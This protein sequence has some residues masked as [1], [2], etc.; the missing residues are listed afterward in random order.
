M[1]NPNYQQTAL[2]GGF[3]NGSTFL[4]DSFM[5][6]TLTTMAF[7]VGACL[8]L[9][10]PAVGVCTLNGTVS[11]QQIRDGMN[12]TYQIVVYNQGAAVETIILTDT[13]SPYLTNVAY[14]YPSGPQFV[15]PDIQQVPGG[16]TLYS[17]NVFGL[18]MGNKASYTFTIAGIVL[19]SCETTTVSN[20]VYCKLDALCSAIPLE[21]SALPTPVVFQPLVTGLTVFM[22]QSQPAPVEGDPL[23]YMITVTNVG[24]ATITSLTVVDTVSAVLLS[25]TTTEAGFPGTVTAADVAGGT[26][27]V[28]SA[29]GPA[30]LVPGAGFV[31]TVS[32]T[33]GPVCLT[34][35]VGNTAYV[36]GTGECGQAEQLSNATVFQ[37]V[38]PPLD[39]TVVNEPCKQAIGV[40]EPFSYRIVVTNTGGA[41]LNDLTVVDTVSAVLMNATTDQPFGWPAPVVTTT[42]Q[43]TKYVWSGTGLGMAPGTS[44]TFTIDGKAGLVC[45]TTAVSNTACAVATSCNLLSRC[46]GAVGNVVEPALLGVSVF[47]ASSPASPGVGDPFS[48][49]IVVTNVGYATVTSVTV[50]D[51]ISPV[52]EGLTTGQPAG[53]GAPVVT[54]VAGGTRCVWSASSLNLVPGGAYTFTITG[55]VGQPPC[56]PWPI[57]NT[58]YVIAASSCSDLSSFTNVVGTVLGTNTLAHTSIFESLQGIQASGDPVTYRIVVTNAGSSN[59]SSIMVI[60]TMPPV[61]KITATD[62]PA[63]FSPPSTSQVAGG[64]RYVWSATGVSLDPGAS[65]TFSMTGV[66]GWVCSVVDYTTTAF[67]SLTG[68]CGNRSTSSE[69]GTSLA[70][71]VTPF[72]TSGVTVTNLQTLD[73]PVTGAN[74]T[75]RIVVQ[76]SGTSTLTA[77]TLT[78]TVPSC[79]TGVTYDYE[80]S[81]T[82]SAPVIASVAGGTRY[83][84]YFTGSGG[85]KPGKCYTFTITGKIGEVCSTTNAVNIASAAGNDSCSWVGWVN[86]AQSSFTVEPYVF[87]YTVV[88]EQ[89]PP[90]PGIGDPFTYRIIVTNVG[91]ATVDQ[92]LV[93]DTVSPVVT[94]AKADQDS[95]FGPPVITHVAGGTRYVWSASGLSMIPGLAYTFTV[96]GIVGTVAAPLAVSDTAWAAASSSCASIDAFSNP[97]GFTLYPSTPVNVVAAKFQ[98]PANPVFG[99]PLGYLI[100]AT[101]LGTSA[102]T[103]LVVVDTVSPIIVGIGTDQPSGWPTP[104]VVSAVGAGTRYEWSASGLNLLPGEQYTFTI[105]GYVGMVCAPTTVGNTAFVRASDGLVSIQSL[106]N[107][108]AAVIQPPDVD[109]T[110]VQQQ[111]PAG[112]ASGD[113]V[114]W[115][116]VVTNTGAVTITSL[117]VVD[118]VSPYVVGVIPSQPGGWP[119]PAVS[120]VAGGTRYVWS[121]TG[122]LLAPGASLT[123]EVNGTVGIACTPVSVTNTAY[124]IAGD[125]CASTGMFTNETRFN[126]GTD[127][128]M[129]LVKSYNMLVPPYPQVGE[130]LKYRI[131]IINNGSVPL[132]NLIVTDTLPPMLTGVTYVARSLSTGLDEFN[133]VVV[134]SGASGTIYTWSLPPAGQ[135]LDPGEEYQIDLDATIGLVCAVTPLPNAVQV[136]HNTLCGATAMVY[137]M[138][139]YT[140]NPPTTSVTV[141]K[142]QL[143]TDGVYP[144]LAGTYMDWSRTTTVTAG[145]TVLYQINVRNSG[146]ATITDLMVTDTLSSYDGGTPLLWSPLTNIMTDQ[147][148]GFGAATVI[149]MPASASI[150]SWSNVGPLNMTPG[151]VYTFT[152]VGT[153]DMV[154]QPYAESNTAYVMAR[155]DCA[156]VRMTTNDTYFKIRVPTTSVSV[157]KT[158]LEPTSG[159]AYTG[160]PIKYQILVTNTGEATIRNLTVF[161]TVSPTFLDA[162]GAWATPE[163]TDFSISPVAGSGSRY[164]WKSVAGT[165]NWNSGTYLPTDP[166]AN[167]GLAPGAS[168]ILDFQGIAGIA[169][170]Q[171]AI[172]NSAQVTATS[173]YGSANVVSNALSWTHLPVVPQLTVTTSMP[174]RISVGPDQEV[175]YVLRMTNT[176][177]DTLTDLTFTDTVPGELMGSAT[178]YAPTEFGTPTIT[179]SQRPTGGTVYSWSVAPGSIVMTPGMSYTFTISGRTGPVCAPSIVVNAA[180]A[181]GRG[182]VA[183][184]LSPCGESRSTWEVP[185][186]DMVVKIYNAAGELVRSLTSIQVDKAPT[187]FRFAYTD[188]GSCTSYAGDTNLAFSPDGDCVND[189]VVF[190]FDQLID[191][192][193]N[194]YR[195]TWDGKND[196]GGWVVNGDYTVV[197]VSVD[198][199]TGNPVVVN[200]P[201]KLLARRTTVTVRILNSAGEEVAALPIVSVTAGVTGISIEPNPYEPDAAGVNTVVIKLKDSAGNWLDADNNSGNDVTGLSWY[202][203]TCQAANHICA[204][205][206]DGKFVKSGIYVVKAT[207]VGANGEQL[208]VTGDLTVKAPVA[209]FADMLGMQPGGVHVL[210]GKDGVIRPRRGEEAIILVWPTAAGKLQMHIFDSEGRLVRDIMQYTSGGRPEQVRWDC[211]DSTGVLV[212]PGAYYLF[213]KGPGI[214]RKGTLPVLVAR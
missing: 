29:A 67:A 186:L 26:R 178:A 142:R 175:T 112:P 200:K 82:F 77:L 135:S 49:R 150:Y 8:I 91:T 95:A 97:T 193:G 4:G 115:R 52:I 13:V 120:T 160:A 61:I 47:M 213:V 21:I 9:P 110:A 127:F 34:T 86:S 100:V 133:P 72:Y 131:Q 17:W 55:T 113:P 185:P 167:M 116:T 209:Y 168:I 33:V 129:A 30:L 10:R 53:F 24:T 27:W 106:S 87:D 152:I 174:Y 20:T 108:V 54:Q 107:P 188:S 176:G 83:V 22:T 2:R 143:R 182:A 45:G 5:K 130:N 39:F 136:V 94:S 184:Y 31:F 194:S 64:T 125:T 170:T 144:A 7:L 134:T 156:T 122:L 12:L 190:T 114:T 126:V 70:G 92:I 117:T 28:W 25:Q 210:G 93:V 88:K 57:S 6:F 201:I 69:V 14:S 71:Q 149:K 180:F 169:C 90:A 214:T 177:T 192:N 85:I 146:T 46:S 15:P 159:K 195:A 208:A 19:P 205:P 155:S 198:P 171:T 59:A 202:G 153:V 50:V 96:S 56:A 74:I 79:E 65:M 35:T 66:A 124:V 123:F 3:K 132:T 84:W 43:G 162:T 58:A 16:G 105:A 196:L 23:T 203:R 111:V 183:P 199:Q 181:Y 102:I 157:V 80:T 179:N 40:G 145:E 1:P 137:K 32:G 98:N 63:G 99:G 211:R 68:P 89:T 103:D 173:M 42:A 148:A 37:M 206:T 158:M 139:G 164:I 151:T 197:V 75:Y 18:S 191:Q 119:T 154:F 41:V 48:Y 128:G 187:D 140:V 51:T 204:S 78:D 73:A 38:A 161:D 36:A 101:N 207:S 165:Y 118:T 138:G 212:V 109:V 60:T 62:Q 141:S 44:Y 172:L 104:T 121:N 147:P 163:M 76:N 11:K 166:A 189:V 81:P